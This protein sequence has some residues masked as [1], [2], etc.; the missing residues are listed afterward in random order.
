MGVEVNG[1]LDFPL[2]A[3]NQAE[4]LE[5]AGLLSLLAINGG[6]HV[7]VVRVA[8]VKLDRFFRQWQG[9]VEIAEGLPDSGHVVVGLGVVGIGL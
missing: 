3:T 1:C 8:A 7:V 5:D 4:C 2:E 9:A 6:E